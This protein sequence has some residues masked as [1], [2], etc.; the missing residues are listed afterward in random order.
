MDPVLLASPTSRPA[1]RF[2][3]LDALRGLAAVWVYLFHYCFTEAVVRHFPRLHNLFKAG[4]R[5]VPMFFVISGFCLALSARTALKREEAPSKL[6]GRRAWRIFPPFW[7][8]ILF[9]VAILELAALAAPHSGVAAPLETYT[10]WDW[11]KIATLTRYLDQSAGI[12][13]GRF[14]AI[15]GAYWTLAVEFQFYVIV[16]AAMFT[17][18]HFYSTLLGITAISLVIYGNES[19]YF[20]CS[21]CGICLSHWPWFSLGLAVYWLYERDWNPDR[22]FGR[23]W[24]GLTTTL[25]AAILGTIIVLGMKGIAIERM[26]FAG[27]C[28][29]GIWCLLP[30]ERELSR[31][32]SGDNFAVRGLLALGAASY[33]IYL[34]HNPAG[35]VVRGA[36][37]SVLHQES[38]GLDVLVVGITVYTGYVFYR[39]CEEPFQRARKSRR[40]ERQPVAVQ[41][42]AN[43]EVRKAA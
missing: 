7:C 13:F 8:S 10:P 35:I 5:A 37:K 38:I 20:A 11:F 43:R 33:S 15:N 30:L 14:G 26:A 12:Y 2:Q 42:P 9:T 25:V 19:W 22:L 29:V 40:D 18:R 31:R 32:F 6:L 41:I 39:C 34:I 4:D 1:F 16:C 28:A 23:H 27:L 36:L 17:G 21:E 24:Q 3:S